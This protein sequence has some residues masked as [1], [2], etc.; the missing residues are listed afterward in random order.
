[1]TKRVFV[2]RIVSVLA[3]LMCLLCAYY[4]GFAAGKGHRLDGAI[5]WAGEW[6]WYAESAEGTAYLLDEKADCD[7]T[8][9]IDFG[10]G[11]WFTLPL[12]VW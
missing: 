6:A 3:V 12:Y 10:D 1:M 8:V 2:L 4:A 7:G 5:A 9:N 11:Q